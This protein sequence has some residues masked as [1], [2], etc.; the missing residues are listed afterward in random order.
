MASV[1]AEPRNSELALAYPRSSAWCRESLRAPTQRSDQLVLSVSAT[2]PDAQMF[3]K[4]GRTPVLAHKTHMVV[5]GGRANIITAVELRRACEPDSHAVIAVLAKHELAV[6][7]PPRELVGDRGYGSEAANKACS[8]R[9]V[10]PTLA[11]RAL[12]NRYGSIHRDR[13]AYLPERDIFVCP[14]HQELHRYAENRHLRAS[15][16]RP[17]RGTCQTCSFKAQCAPGRADRSVSRRWDGDMWEEWQRHLRS[18]HARHMFRRRQVVSERAF[19]QGK[20]NHGLGRAQFR[21]R[22][23]MRVQALMTAAAMN[24]KQLVRRTPVAQSG[25]AVAADFDV[26]APPALVSAANSRRSFSLECYRCAFSGGLSRS[27]AVDVS[28]AREPLHA[29][30]QRP[31]GR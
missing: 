20:A 18:R 21:G 17:V 23:N 16:Y 25:I 9:G 22:T 30:V 10:L 15:L 12:N 24:V 29:G 11:M 14:N 6:H 3:R 13:F 31:V 5:D 8:Q 7:R 26:A 4:P 27:S 1:P 28:S 2:D 19:A